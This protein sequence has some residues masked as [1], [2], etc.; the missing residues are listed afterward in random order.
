MPSRY[1]GWGLVIPEGMAAGLPVIATNRMG[2]AL[3]LIRPGING[4]L[5]T[6]GDLDELAKAIS[7]AVQLNTQKLTDMSVNARETAKYC[8][9]EQGVK[10]FHHAVHGTLQAWSG[11]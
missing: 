5:I 9:L 6:A 4:W 11:C 8:G 10:T 3:D 7:E 1:D 2:A